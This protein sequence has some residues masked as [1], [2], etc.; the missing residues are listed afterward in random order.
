MLDS[1]SSNATS[2]T[3]AVDQ[4]RRLLCQVATRIVAGGGFV[5]LTGLLF[6]DGHDSKIDL[7]RAIQTR[8]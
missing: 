1:A 8:R 7:R 6:R 3:T 5:V 2:E 4:V